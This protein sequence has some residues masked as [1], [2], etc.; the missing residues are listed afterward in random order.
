M[1]SMRDDALKM[2]SMLVFATIKAMK[3]ALIMTKLPKHFL[4]LL[5]VLQPVDD[6]TSAV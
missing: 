5:I 2:R 3:V 4:L 1:Q 6:K